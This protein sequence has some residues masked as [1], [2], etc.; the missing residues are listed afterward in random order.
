ML[1]SNCGKDIPFVGNV[2]PYCHHNKS[3][4]KQL[5]AWTVF[6]SIV[7]AGIGIYLYGCVGLIV[8]FIA[9]GIVGAICGFA[10]ANRVEAENRDRGDT[11]PINPQ[12]P[13]VNQASDNAA[14]YAGTV[15]LYKV[16]GVEK[17]TGRDVELE[18]AARNDTHAKVKA[19]LQG[20][21]VTEVHRT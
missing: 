21:V 7:G 5:T 13:R 18:I 3:G 11:Y 15:A 9:G 6:F 4:D 1:C 16:V 10:V 14:K 2:C 8:G 12:P 17:S 20:I 19:E